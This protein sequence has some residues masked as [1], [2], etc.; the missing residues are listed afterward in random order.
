MLPVDALL[1][2]L[3]SR[4]VDALDGKPG[5]IAEIGKRLQGRSNRPVATTTLYRHVG[6]L[7]DCGLLKVV[8]LRPTD[9]APT[10]VYGLDFG[11]SLLD[12]HSVDH[13]RM[14]GLVT[15]VQSTTR[16]RFEAVGAQNATPLPLARLAVFNKT[17]H[18]TDDQVRTLRS[19]IAEFTTSHVVDTPPPG[20]R[21]QYFAF[22]TCP[23]PDGAALDAVRG[24]DCRGVF[25]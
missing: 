18:L 17:L 14:L 24:T 5:T 1:H 13:E 21:P 20:T 11:T 7:V 6:I 22:F 10:A 19:M 8:E 25:P 15:M 23:E 16:R 3:R 4:I 9:G 12:P 2:P